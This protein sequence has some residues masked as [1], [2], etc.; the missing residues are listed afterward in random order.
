MIWAGTPFTRKAG[1]AA[2]DSLPYLEAEALAR[3]VLANM[4]WGS[5]L[6]KGFIQARDRRALLIRQADIFAGL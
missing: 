1:Q 4:V 5:Q 3:Y 6:A 2:Y